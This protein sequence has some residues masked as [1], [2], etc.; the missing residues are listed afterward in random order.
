MSHSKAILRSQWLRSN[1]Q[2]RVVNVFLVVVGVLIIAASAKIKVPMWPV[3]MSLQTLAIFL[4]A[5][6]YGS[7]LGVA[8]VISYLAVGA[9]GYPVFQSTPERGIGLAYMVGPTAGYLVGFVVMTYIVGRA[10][11]LGWW[12]STLKIGCAMLAGEMVLLLLGFLWLVWLFGL[13]QAY[14]YGIGPFIIPDLVKVT[15]AA[16]LVSVLPRVTALTRQ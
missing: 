14:V 9:A 3:E 10:A 1:G 5:G 8:T 16:C 12:R 2:A 15:L 11:D 4:I 13:Q 6:T 7:R